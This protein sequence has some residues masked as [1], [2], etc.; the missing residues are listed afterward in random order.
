MSPANTKII[1]D[2]TIIEYLWTRLP[3]NKML[4]DSPAPTCEYF[5]L[6]RAQEVIELSVFD[7]EGNVG[8]DTLNIFNIRPAVCGN[9]NIENEEICD[10]NSISCLTPQGYAG[11]KYCNAQCSAFGDC[12]SGLSCGDHIRNGTEVCDGNTQACTTAGGYGGTQSC[13]GQCTAFG[14]CTTTLRCGDAICSAPPET[15]ANCPQDCSTA[16]SLTLEVENMPT[17]TTGAAVTGGWN[18]WSNGYIQ[19]SVNFPTTG[20]YNFQVL[21]RGAIA[22]GVW[23]IM[24]IRIDQVVKSTFTVNNTNWTSFSSQ[25][26]VP[27]GSH[28]VAIAFTNDLYAPPADRNLYVDKVIITK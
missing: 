14:T 20:T 28:N 23:P 5:T 26:S 13:N 9:G 3:D 8:K 6:G 7:R 1:L 4:C 19:Q 2:G 25:I 15:T 17:K 22:A 24:E 21:A 18:I 10:D 12:I 27:A 11:T 16:F